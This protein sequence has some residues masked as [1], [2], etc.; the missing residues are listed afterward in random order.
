MQALKSIDYHEG[1]IEKLKSRVEEI[2]DEIF[3]VRKKRDEVV[4]VPTD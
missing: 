4:E 1:A 3:K 2:D